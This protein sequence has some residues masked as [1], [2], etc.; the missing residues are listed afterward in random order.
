VID[1]AIGKILLPLRTLL[2]TGSL[3]L[4]PVRTVPGHVAWQST[5]ESMHHKLDLPEEQH[6]AG[7]RL[8]TEKPPAQS[9]WV[10]TQ[11]DKLP[12]I[13][14]GHSK[15]RMLCQK[16]GVLHQELGT[17]TLKLRAWDLH[18][19]MARKRGSDKLTGL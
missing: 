14:D 10:A 16:V 8:P 1:L 3:V 5:L 19:C 12:A 11:L 15:C 2:L 13:G 17:L 7:A 4:L 18:H 9:A 6:S